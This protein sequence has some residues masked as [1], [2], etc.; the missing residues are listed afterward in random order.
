MKLV[1]SNVLGDRQSNL[2]SKQKHVQFLDFTL[3]SMRTLKFKGQPTNAFFAAVNQ[4][5]GWSSPSYNYCRALFR[6]LRSAQRFDSHLPTTAERAVG[7]AKHLID[8]S[9][10]RICRSTFEL[11]S[12]SY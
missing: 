12:A 1:V 9:G 2:R 10:K 4:M 6:C 11:E 8:D 7:A 5:F 3:N